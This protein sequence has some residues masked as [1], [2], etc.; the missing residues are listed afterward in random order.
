MSGIEDITSE[1]L[2]EAQEK[3]D[4]ILAKAEEQV[5]KIS[6]NIEKD[7][8]EKMAEMRAQAEKISASNASR[9][10]A[11]A[12]LTVRNRVLDAKQ[13]VISTAFE[14]AVKKLLQM[15]D[16]EYVKIV[17]GMVKRIPNSE[18]MKLEM[19]PRNADFMTGGFLLKGEDGI[20]LNFSFKD[21][22]DNI[23]EKIEPQVMKRLGW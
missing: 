22:A 8:N 17:D 12:Q 14:N 7:I 2:R 18:K 10:L 21:L 15:P 9:L 23:R 6:E 1:I 13:E 4:A 11:S 19:I 20:I 16:D 3:A 5:G